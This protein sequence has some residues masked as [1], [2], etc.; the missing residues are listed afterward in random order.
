MKPEPEHTLA[1]VE[2]A[3]ADVKHK[4]SIG[5]AVSAVKH[6]T[7]EP[8]THLGKDIKHSD[9]ARTVQHGAEKAKDVVDIG[10]YDTTSKASRAGSHVSK[11]IK[12]AAENVKEKVEDVVAAGD[13]KTHEAGVKGT[14]AV[15]QSG[16]RVSGTTTFLLF[17]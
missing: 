12:H 13:R 5:K 15:Q 2:D 8:V 4:S 11:D 3:A 6:A 14:R 10:T 1:K 16:D 9:T 17:V 7:V